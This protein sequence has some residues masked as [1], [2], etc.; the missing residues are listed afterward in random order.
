LNDVINDRTG[1]DYSKMKTAFERIAQVN[2]NLKVRISEMTVQIDKSQY[3]DESYGQ[4]DQ[5]LNGINAC[6]EASNCGGF[7]TWG[8]ASGGDYDDLLWREE[9][10]EIQP[11]STLEAVKERLQELKYY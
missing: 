11:K 10:G 7:A 2:S 8:V 3:D 5:F 6:F 4:A 9:D 1:K